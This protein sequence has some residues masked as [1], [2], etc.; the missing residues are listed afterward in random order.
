MYGEYAFFPLDVDLNNFKPRALLDALKELQ[1]DSDVSFCVLNKYILAKFV[2]D[3]PLYF[4]FKY[5]NETYYLF[6]IS[7]FLRFFNKEVINGI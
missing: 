6:H 1:H 2:S 7:H 3:L 5:K 4:C